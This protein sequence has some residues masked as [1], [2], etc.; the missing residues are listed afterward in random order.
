MNWKPIPGW[1]RYEASTA[2]DIRVAAN[3]RVLK[4][5]P[6][7]GDGY[8][9]VDLYEGPNPGAVNRTKRNRKT[10]GV[11]IV[12]CRTFYGPRPSARHEAAHNNGKRLDN[13]MGNLRWATRLENEQDKLYHGTA[14]LGES[15]GRSKLFQYQALAI[16]NDPRKAAVIAADYGIGSRAVSKIKKGHRWPHLQPAKT[17]AAP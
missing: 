14:P 1:P 9:V 7:A 17:E 2:G 6:R 12:I 4:Q 15:N 10:V 8:L 5:R 16:L 3:G 11:N 13:S